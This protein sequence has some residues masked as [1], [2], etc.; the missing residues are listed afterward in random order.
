[1]LQERQCI[2]RVILPVVLTLVRP[3]TFPKCEA[4]SRHPSATAQAQTRRDDVTYALDVV[5]E[6]FE[7]T[8]CSKFIHASTS[9]KWL[10]EEKDFLYKK[11]TWDLFK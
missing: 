10:R 1:M 11:R 3:N 7:P 4:A 9:D 2:V 8:L 5:N 6:S